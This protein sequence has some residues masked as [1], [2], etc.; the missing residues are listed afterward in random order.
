MGTLN[1]VLYQ[2]EIPQNTGNIMRTCVA[3]NTVLHLIEPLGFSLEEKEIKRSGAN[4][5]KDVKYIRYKDWDEFLAK[6]TGKMYFLT[7]YGL[8]NLYDVHVE[9][10]QE[11]YYF[12][13]G[14]ESSGIPKEILQKNLEN[15]IRLPMT[16]KV[17]ALN[18]SNCAAIIV[19]EALRQ[20]GFPNLCE[21]EPDTTSELHFK[22]KNFLLED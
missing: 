19:Y 4:Y 10:P 17:R 2:P 8:H 12:V 1:L 9:D 18:V 11:D 7:R 3:T 5:V 20:Q 13:L 22:G 21:F 16:D 15:C 14:K 6:N